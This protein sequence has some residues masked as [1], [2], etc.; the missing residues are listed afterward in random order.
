VARLLRVHWKLENEGPIW[1]RLRSSYGRPAVCMVK[2][3][4]L[5]VGHSRVVVARSS[6]KK[7][8]RRQRLYFGLRELYVEIEI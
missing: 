6:T 1:T 3:G 7:S 5:D 2:C 4:A 8:L